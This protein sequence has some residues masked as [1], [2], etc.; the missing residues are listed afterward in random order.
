MSSG[1]RRGENTTH[2][3]HISETLYDN[4]V[5]M[6]RHLFDRI[7]LAFIALLWIWKAAEYA[8]RQTGLLDRNLGWG[9]YVDFTIPVVVTI[10]FLSM[11]AFRRIARLL[12]R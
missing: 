1:T 7:G 4:G 3:A 6:N 10:A 9:F 11:E 2:A 12:A 8:G 5:R